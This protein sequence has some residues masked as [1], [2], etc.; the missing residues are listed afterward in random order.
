M[1]GQL[2]N[3]EPKHVFLRKKVSHFVQLKND[4]YY[5][6]MTPTVKLLL[7]FIVCRSSNFC[8][9]SKICCCADCTEHLSFYVKKWIEKRKRK[10]PRKNY[11]NVSKIIKMRNRQTE[12]STSLSIFQNQ[13]GKRKMTKL[14]DFKQAWN[15]FYFWSWK[16]K[17]LNWL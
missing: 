13:S 3:S 6:S 17:K 11:G 1:Q 10:K 2:L 7:W 8:S 9:F 12:L 16:K 14:T 5:F 4:P 15:W